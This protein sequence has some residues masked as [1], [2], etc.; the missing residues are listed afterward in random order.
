[1]LFGNEKKY[2]DNEAGRPLLLLV[3]ITLGALLLHGDVSINGRQ[4]C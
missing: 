4:Y 1:M 2:E 3:S